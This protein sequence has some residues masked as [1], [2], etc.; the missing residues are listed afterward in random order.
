VVLANS[1][2][3][4]AGYFA[5]AALIWGFADATMSQ[6]HSLKEFHTAESKGRK[7]RVV[8]LSDIHIVAKAFAARAAGP[9]RV[10]TSA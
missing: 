3:L 6:P 5:V 7:S 9:A 1:V 8:R 2:V 10:A 4:V